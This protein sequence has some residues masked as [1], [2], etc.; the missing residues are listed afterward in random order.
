LKKGDRFAHRETKSAIPAG[1]AMI[2]GCVCLDLNKFLEVTT[3][4]V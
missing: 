3:T 2:V 1:W 4:T